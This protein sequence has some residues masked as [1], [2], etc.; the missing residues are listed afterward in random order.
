LLPLENGIPSPDTLERVFAK[1]NPA[2]F[3][4][5][6]GRWMAAA[7]ETCG[8]IPIAIDGKSLR[9][10]PKA[11]RTGCLHLV[12]AWAT[13]NRLTLGQVSV[14][15][16]TNEIA[17][18]PELLRILELQGAIVT[19][20]AAGC[21]VENAQIIREQEGHYLLAVKG[22]QPTLHAGVESIFTQA[23]NSDLANLSWDGQASRESA[24]GRWEQRCVTVLYDPQGLPT[25][26]P[27]VAAVIQV[28]REQEVEGKKESSTHS[29]LRAKG[30]ND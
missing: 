5:A 29:Y 9:S 19:L 28:D 6:F 17:V 15:E 8:L 22:N 7:C 23:W 26:W 14:P 13:A 1:L 24:H 18:I 3:R 12:S 20:D 10:A 4:E 16:G 2:A 30:K 27:D 21:Q 25:N 11:T